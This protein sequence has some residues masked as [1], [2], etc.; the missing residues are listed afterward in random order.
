MIR[1]TTPKTKSELITL[2]LDIGAKSIGWAL[3]SGP[4]SA[5]PQIKALGVRIFEAGVDG[6]IES[7][8]DSSRAAVRRMARQMRRQTYRRVQ[9]K[10][11]LFSLLQ[12]GAFLPATPD[13][14][15]T[16]RDKAIKE[17]DSRILLTLAAQYGDG[18]VS[19]KLPYVLRAEALSRPLT[20]EELGRVFYHLGERRG[21]KAN[22]RS[23]RQSEETGKVYAGIAD[24]RLKKGANTLGEYFANL[25]PT[26]NRIRNHYIGRADYEEEFQRIFDFQQPHH[27]ALT[28]KYRRRL[29]QCLFWQRPLKSQKSLIGRCSLQPAHR[30]CPMAHPI[31]QE[32]RL[33]QAV[34]HLAAIDPSGAV[35]ALNGVERDKLLA[36]LR[37]DGDLTF[38]RLRSLLA[39]P[40][41]TR[42]N[43]EE[44]G[45]KKL[46]GDRTHKAMTDAIGEQWST[47]SAEDKATLV[48]I[49]R[50]SAASEDLRGQLAATLPQLESSWEAL[51]KVA[52]EDNFASHCKKVLADLVDRMKDGIPYA[53]AKVDY[54]ATHNL[55]GTTKPEDQLPPLRE[56]LPG[57][58]NPAV[59]RALT[60]LRKIVNEIVRVYGKPD[61]V[62]IELARDLKKPRHIRQNLS[63]KMRGREGE[64]SA[65]TQQLKSH[66]ISNPSRADIEKVLLAT[67]CGW[68]C[69]YTGSSFGMGD[70]V[71]E[72]ARVDVEHIYPRKYLDDSYANKTLC[73][74]DENRSRKMD[75]LPFVAYSG[76]PARYQQIMERVRSFKSELCDE[77]VRRFLAVEVEAGF[78]S[79]QLVD[80]AY[81][82]REAARYVGVL[83]GGIVDVRSD[84]RVRTSSGR[85]SALLRSAWK[86]NTILGTE[87]SPKGRAV[88]HRHH[89]VDA[90]V[91]AL[92]TDSI[93]RSV[94][95]SAER[96]AMRPS[97]RWR[98]EVP[99]QP[100]LL[101]LATAEVKKI[102][103]SHRVD[104]R[105]AGRLHEDSIYSP[106][107][108]DGNGGTYHVIRKPLFNLTAKSI[109][110][111]QIIDPTVRRIVQEHYAKL[112]KKLSTTNPAKL[113]A[114]EENLP[115]LPNRNGPPIVIRKV[116]I[117]VRDSAERIGDQQHRHR[118]IMKDADGLHHTVI[119]AVRKNGKETW[120]DQ[121]VTRLLANDRHR[122]GDPVVQMEWGPDEEFMF[123]LC[124]GDS[125]EMTGQ[126]GEREI[127]VVRGVADQNIRVLKAWDASGETS[128]PQNR[129]RTA[130]V[131]KDRKA[132]PVIVT[133]AGRVFRRGG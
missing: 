47:L 35:R 22:R 17:V 127:Y 56:F 124:K 129:I 30:R 86:L 39:L 21:F 11:R 51:E 40:K 114:A 105:L 96:Y 72:H 91:V 130:S 23:D 61:M 24:I 99:D 92:T 98:V 44:G 97:G 90:L 69:P 6:D 128:L 74:A 110:S 89:A 18:D 20:A 8:Q 38:P 33:L 107:R 81:A 109:A 7:G 94:T 29:K 120:A 49:V 71:G 82:S 111:D 5:E 93:I 125:F 57:M 118:H 15:A 101:T 60:E 1:K 3:V 106:P 27:P 28:P 48:G 34:N 80:T 12:S 2:G 4:E 83:Y 62:R 58:T 115:Y 121:S 79:R 67:E 16:A 122:V 77:K 37:S 45:E 13:T 85:L 36:K 64:R 54:E 112:C 102:V 70:L 55:G 103:V 131:F 76:D 46:L 75:R 88:D 14:Q 95:N 66:G 9:R 113:F 43:L 19:Q 132:A 78:A 104:R 63:A 53:T 68:V 10:R 42:F 41:G 50:G 108:P 31:A 65:A 123:H 100:T 117:R 126:D 25:D 59:I 133:P 87:A 119:L 84:K 52:L 116:R 32:F 26:Q 73:V